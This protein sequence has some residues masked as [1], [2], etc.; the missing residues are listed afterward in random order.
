MEETNK[1]DLESKLCDVEDDDYSDLIAPPGP[2]DPETIWLA[3]KKKFN[4]E[5]ESM[6]KLMGMIGIL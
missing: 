4:L 5:S 3:S 1:N 2:N 6:D